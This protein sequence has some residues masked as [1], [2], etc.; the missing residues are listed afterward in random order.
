MLYISNMICF[1]K[2]H[3]NKLTYLLINVF[4]YYILPIIFQNLQFETL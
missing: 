2:Y 1:V 3:H 4:H